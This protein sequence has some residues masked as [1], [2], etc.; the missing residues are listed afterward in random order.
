MLQLRLHRRWF[1]S[2][3]TVGELT[4]GSYSCYTLEDRIRALG[5]KKFGETAIPAGLYRVAITYSPRFQKHLPEVF[6]VPKFTNIRI[7]SGNRA[8]DTQGC[9]LVGTER[10]G[11]SLLFSRAALGPIIDLIQDEPSTL[12]IVDAPED[13]SEYRRLTGLSPL[14]PGGEA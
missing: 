6:D 1:T 3:S 4:A 11:N 9:I 10:R 2:M 13:V 5:T 14:P 8:E 12:L 7:H